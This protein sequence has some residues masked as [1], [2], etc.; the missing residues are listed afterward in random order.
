VTR[1]H[2]LVVVDRF[3]DT[4]DVLRAVFEPRGI[5]VERR[6]RPLGAGP[7]DSSAELFVFDVESVHAS[8]AQAGDWPAGPRVVIGPGAL[9]ETREAHKATSTYLAKPFEYAELIRAIEQ[10]LEP[11][12]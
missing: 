12:R 8:H 10:L 7:A 3:P 2:R 1:E 5:E 4:A 9:P 11:S 6:R